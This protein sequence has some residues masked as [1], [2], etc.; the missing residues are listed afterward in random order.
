[1][2]N[3]KEKAPPMLYIYKYD[4]FNKLQSLNHTRFIEENKNK[5]HRYVYIY[6][7]ASSLVDK[8]K[9]V[10]EKIRQTNNLEFSNL[11]SP[12]VNFTIN[13]QL[14]AISVINMLFLLY[15]CRSFG[16]HGK[17]QNSSDSNIHT[18]QITYLAYTFGKYIERLE[19]RAYD[20]YTY[21]IKG[22]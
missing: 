14:L 11:P 8:I 7:L 10:N 9:V 13:C 12:L 5:F 17:L 20:I 6:I 18:K 19:N 4:T 2:G 15:A 1:M 22:S 16:F 3:L 21:I